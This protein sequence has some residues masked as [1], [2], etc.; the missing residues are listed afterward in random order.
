MTEKIE[1][2]AGRIMLQTVKEHGLL[3]FGNQHE[4]VP[5]RL[6]FDKHLT[7]RA[8]LAWQLIKYKAKE[9]QSGLFPSYE[10]LAE[11]LSEK[12]YADEKLSRKLISQT[13]LLLRL[14]RW[15]TLCETARNEHGQVMGNIYLLHDEPMPVI[16]T[17]QLNDDYLRLLEKSVK[18]NDPAVRNV[19]VDIVDSLMS[20]DAQ[21][22][23]LSHIDWM[24]ARYKEYQNRRMIL[25]DNQEASTPF[26]QEIQEK[27]LSSHMEL[28]ETTTE[29]SK[30]TLSSHMELSQNTQSSNRELRGKNSA[31]SLIL[32]SVP[33]GNSALQQY[34]TST[35][36][37][38]N[39]C[40]NEYCTGQEAEIVWPEEIHFSPLEKQA[41]VQ[42][43]KGLD[44]G[45]CKALLFELEQRYLKGEV[46]KTKGYLM[47]LIQRA[48]QGDF[49][50]YLYEQFLAKQ[51]SQTQR[52]LSK[53]KPQK[54]VNNSAI[55]LTAEERQHRADSI[56]RFRETLL[57]R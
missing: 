20:D 40:T 17:L 14:T 15:L 44:L 24:R 5:A 43:M 33:Y 37:C 22:H 32:D 53:P 21:W 47:S 8:K 45:I 16:D 52:E 54:I 10:V 11:L 38:T 2:S 23:Y 35:N 19:A 13:L 56:R 31:K 27:I 50:P 36:I 25:A 7:S 12:N 6:L 41:I 26:T 18:H 39:I 4:T 46:K 29:L 28:S 1:F 48:H 55:Q 51:P 57:R 9:F 3:F 42:S 49:K 30:N 34:S